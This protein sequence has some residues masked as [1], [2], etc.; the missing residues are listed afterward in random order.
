VTDQA[1]LRLVP[2]R[3]VED[4]A[5]AVALIAGV[6]EGHPPAHVER[7]AEVAGAIARQAGLDDATTS[8]CIVGGWLHDIG[9]VALPDAVLAPSDPAGYVDSPLVRAH[10]VLGAELVTR[11][12]ELAGAAEGIRHHHERFDGSGYPD[13][14]AGDEI[15]L[16]ARVVAVADAVAFLLPESC[17]DARGRK[18]AARRLNHLAG[19]A[20]DPRLA[21][22]ALELLAG[23]AQA[24]GEYL[25]RTA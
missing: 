23:E 5:R 24:A 21:A 12:A 13:G 14:L 1:H 9:M 4:I 20:L 8:Q 6:R 7:V 22:A 16:A 11:V 25:P 2:D 19:S 15:P 3:S 17:V 10:V 18:A